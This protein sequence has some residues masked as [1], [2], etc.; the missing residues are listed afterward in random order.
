MSQT[1]PFRFGVQ[2]A[3]APSGQEWAAAARQAEDLGFSTLFMPDHFGDQL[4]PVPALMAAACATT[5]LRVGALVFDNDYRHPLVLAKEMATI[6][7]LSGGRLEI[8]LGAGWMRS[9]YEESGIAF[10][11]PGT[12]VDRFEEGLAVVAGLLGPDPFSFSGEHYQVTGH[13]LLPKAVQSPRPPILVGGGLRR[14]LSIAGRHADIVGINPTIP[15]GEVDA[16]AAR[17]GTAEATDE[18]L[19]WVRAAAGDRYGD[20]E[21]NLLNF[22]CFVTDDRTSVAE[23]LAP[24][25]G[26]DPEQLLEFPHALLGTVD[27]IC[28]SI[29][30]RRDRWDA[31]YL[32]IQHDAMEAMAPV[33]ARLAGC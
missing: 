29:E 11:P 9:D 7:L 1:R 31:S 3:T 10:D 26:I 22:G 21:V 12:R 6:D 5:E 8:G 24:A 16:E 27:E 2:M 32:V 28:E 19:S 15:N 23:S 17:S 4:A 14:M 13:D 20:M 25:F 30:A 33:V 18:K